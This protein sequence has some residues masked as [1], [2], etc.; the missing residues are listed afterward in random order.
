MSRACHGE[1]CANSDLGL[2]EQTRRAL[3][4]GPA[5]M[6]RTKTTL[7]KVPEGAHLRKPSVISPSDMMESPLEI[8]KRTTV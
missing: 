6:A 3:G 1:Q 4:M 5:A 7:T 8:F 2:A